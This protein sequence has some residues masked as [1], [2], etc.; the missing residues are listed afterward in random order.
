[1]LQQTQVARVLKYWPRW[2]QDF[3]TVQALA[4]APLERV[5]EHW[6]GLGY[7]RR[8]IALQRAAQVVVSAHGG[9]MPRDHDALLAL[10]GVGPATAAG[11]RVFA[12]GEPDIYLET[13][14]RSVFL[15]EFFPGQ[16]GIA[17][18]QL[19]P[20]VEATCDHDDPRSW[21]Y[22]LLDFG[23]YL[24]QTMPNPSRA[25]KHHSRQSAFEGSRRQKR[26]RLLRLVMG[27]GEQGASEAELLDAISAAELAD[28]RPALTT[29]L[30]VSILGDLEAE[31]FI[32]QRD[33]RW[34][35]S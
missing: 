35:I 16:E 5:L 29:A 31:R 20:L 30:L 14:V 21:E 24:K 23:A 4:A 11:V 9:V 15:H 7:N 2:M 22:A 28:G 26:A 27:A 8:A 33:G 1:M 19:I 25:S 18:A 12:F 17:D 6:Q 10:P 34:R 13:N 32:V 3:P